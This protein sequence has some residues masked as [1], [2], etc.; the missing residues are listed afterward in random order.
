[1]L[2]SYFVFWEVLEHCRK[3][4]VTT[5]DLGGIDPFANR[6]VYTFKKETGAKEVELLGEWDWA[7]SFWLRIGRKFFDLEKTEF[8]K[9]Q[10]FI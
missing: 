5:Y 2:A 4:G 6:G 3:L 7:S 9:H 8:Q 1:M 10:A